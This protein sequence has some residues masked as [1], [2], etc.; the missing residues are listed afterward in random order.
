MI[1]VPMKTAMNGGLTITRFMVFIVVIAVA[2]GCRFNALIT[3]TEK[4]KYRP[5]RT[6]A[7]VTAPFSSHGVA[8][9][10]IFEQKRRAL[11]NRL[12][13][14]EASRCGAGTSWARSSGAASS[15]AASSGAVVA[16]GRD[17]EFGRTARETPRVSSLC[18]R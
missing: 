1:G 10:D 15:G 6:P 13:A 3:Q 9:K 17:A 7:P 2:G 8:S 11:M 14:I 5:D 4:M 18:A 12:T 16:D